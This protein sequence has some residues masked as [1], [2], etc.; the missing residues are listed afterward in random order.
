VTLVGD[1]LREH[2]HGDE[3][4]WDRLTHAEDIFFSS[5]DIS[6]DSLWTNSP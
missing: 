4:A 5:K 3:W 1:G 6:N 2:E